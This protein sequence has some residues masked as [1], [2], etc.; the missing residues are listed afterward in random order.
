MSNEVVAGFDFEQFARHG[1]ALAKGVIGPTLVEDALRAVNAAMGD[2]ERVEIYG[3][4]G[5]ENCAPIQ[6]H[7]SVLALLNDSGALQVAEALSQPGAFESADC[8]QVL[9]RF[10]SNGAPWKPVGHIDGVPTRSNQL[11]PRGWI[12][13][14]LLLGVMLSN[15]PAP[16][17]GNFVTWPGSHLAHARWFTEHGPD[18]MLDADGFAD[19]TASP[20]LDVGAPHEVVAEA[21]DMVLAH[22]LLLHTG[23]CNVSPHIRYAVFFRLTHQDVGSHELELT[24]PWRHLAGLADRVALRMP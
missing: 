22:H 7:P 1:W 18:A 24:S 23:G 17:Y 3:F 4:S 13:F 16:G 8:C 21:G 10:P 6:H 14:T 19:E 2:T 15:Q 5:H 9:C 20:G 11:G 12:P